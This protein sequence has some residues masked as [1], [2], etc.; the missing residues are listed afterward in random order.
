MYSLL[1]K[2]KLKDTPLSK[3]VSR[4]V[5]NRG[6]Q[7][8]NFPLRGN[9]VVKSF[10]EHF[11]SKSLGFSEIF[12]RTFCS[13]QVAPFGFYQFECNCLYEISTSL[14]RSVQLG[15]SQLN[16]CVSQSYLIWRFLDLQVD[17]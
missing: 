4:R 14:F 15:F 13:Q 16:L 12:S 7:T 10:E 9:L 8:W 2:E 1:S 6:I 17:V 5:K 3:T 11:V